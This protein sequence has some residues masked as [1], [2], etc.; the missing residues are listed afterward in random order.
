MDQMSALRSNEYYHCCMKI[1]IS[2]GCTAEEQEVGQWNGTETQERIL[3]CI[4]SVVHL[5]C[6]RYRPGPGYSAAMI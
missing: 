1:H 3:D 5:S 2:L 6:E 4:L